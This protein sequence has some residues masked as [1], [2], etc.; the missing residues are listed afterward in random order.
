MRKAVLSLVIILTVLNLMGCNKKEDIN[1][2]IA[3]RLEDYYGL[4][5]NSDMSLI[6]SIYR[7]SYENQL[8]ELVIRVG[9]EEDDLFFDVVVQEMKEIAQKSNQNRNAIHFKSSKLSEDELKL[10]YQ[11][12]LD[13]SIQ[14][15]TGWEHVRGIGINGTGGITITLHENDVKLMQELR[16]DISNPAPINFVTNYSRQEDE[17]GKFVSGVDI[18]KSS[19]YSTVISSLEDAYGPV[20][21]QI[22]IFWKDRSTPYWG[23]YVTKNESLVILIG[24]M[25]YPADESGKRYRNPEY[26]EIIAQMKQI[27]WTKE[28]SH[29]DVEFASAKVNGQLGEIEMQKLQEETLIAHRE[30]YRNKESVWSSVTGYGF[31]DGYVGLMV[32]NLNEE[33]KHAIRETISNPNV[34]FFQDISSN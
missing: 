28:K 12:I 31:Y 25:E 10:L 6:E 29:L 33:K 8:G 3:N 4:V 16:N 18:Y 19:K 20:Y 24:V 34:V 30:N 14:K 27:L 23:A 11:E 26:D 22:P 1:K 13:K 7:G 2:Q 21:E 5:S 9:I 32:R 17:E 15:S